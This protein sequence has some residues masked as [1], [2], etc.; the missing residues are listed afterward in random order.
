[1]SERRYQ[2]LVEGLRRTIEILRENAALNE[3]SLKRT[4]AER[5]EELARLRHD[6]EAMKGSS[7]WRITAPLRF[8][9]FG[10]KLLARSLTDADTRARIRAGLRRRLPVR[11]LAVPKE[12][13]LPYAA[14]WPG[15]EIRNIG[16]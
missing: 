16:T 5:D 6:V 12:Q 14:L 10:V 13:F 11:L 7:S 3:E 1:M 4:L 8:I 9:P 15:S 2:R